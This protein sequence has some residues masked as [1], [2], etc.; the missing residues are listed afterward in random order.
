MNPS[1]LRAISKEVTLIILEAFYKQFPQSLANPSLILTYVNKDSE[2]DFKAKLGLTFAEFYDTVFDVVD[3]LAKSSLANEYSR[4]V[5]A[6]IRVVSEMPGFSITNLY[7]KRHLKEQ[8]RLSY[9]S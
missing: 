8:M 4:I 6:T 2:V 3:N 1:A 7:N 5:F 9:H